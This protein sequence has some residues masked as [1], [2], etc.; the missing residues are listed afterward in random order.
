MELHCDEVHN[1][2]V[3]GNIFCI[4]N[5][6]EYVTALLKASCQFSQELPVSDSSSSSETSLPTLPPQLSSTPSSPPTASVSRTH[7]TSAE[8]T[9]DSST[10]DGTDNQTRRPPRSQGIAIA[11]AKYPRRRSSFKHN[12]VNSSGPGSYNPFGTSEGKH[13]SFMRSAAIFHSS[14]AGSPAHSWSIWN[15]SSLDANSHCPPG[16]SFRSWC[17]VSKPDGSDQSGQ[18]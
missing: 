3:G 17:W 4:A 11:G 1:S 6:N 12:S 14:P 16:S 18:S 10:Q 8:I 5:G 2:L 9:P 15:A 13:G 7:K